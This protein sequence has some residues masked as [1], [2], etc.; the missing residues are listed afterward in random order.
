MAVSVSLVNMK[1]G[2]GKTTLAFNLAW[3]CAWRADMR[4][5]AVDLDPQSNLSQYF[6]GAEN[7]LKYLDA[8]QPTVVDIFEQFSAPKRASG[9]PTLVKPEKLIHRVRRWK[10]GSQLDL[11]PA[12]LELS[13]TLKNPTDKSQL[14]P[15]FLAKISDNYD[16]IIIDCP[17]TE[18]I[19]TAAAYRSSRYVVVPVKPEFLATI[20]LPLLARSLEEFKL[21][22]QHQQLDLAGIIFNDLRRSNT[23][24]EQIASR[25]DVKALAES[26]GWP[27]FDEAAYHSDSYPAGSR[28]GAPIFLTDYA[29]DYVKVEFNNVGEKFLQAIGVK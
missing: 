28:Q 13:W 26:Y 7:Y 12:R 2:V 25:R 19:L 21:M 23:P 15:Q 22:H 17:P 11:V 8:D 24:P 5:L 27:V 3:Y 18:S 1:G 16:L 6:M 20:G 14:L 29:R 9:A 10:D 4:V